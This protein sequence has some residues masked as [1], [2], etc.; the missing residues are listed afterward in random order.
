MR[1][2]TGG[3]EERGEGRRGGG[4]GGGGGEA[5]LLLTASSPFC[6]SR[7]TPRTTSRET[8]LA[9]RSTRTAHHRPVQDQPDHV[10][11]RQVTPAPGL[12][13]GLQLAPGAADHVLADRALE[14]RGQGS[15]HPPRVGTRQ[16][17]ARDQ[18]FD[19]ASSAA[20]SVARRRCATPGSSLPGPQPGARHADRHR[21]EG[22][23]QPPL[24]VAV[25]VPR[26]GAA[27]VPPLSQGRGQLLLEQLLDEAADPLPQARLDRVDQA[28]PA[29]RAA[30]AGRSVLSSSMAWSPPACHRRS[31][32]GERAGHDPAPRFRTTSAT[33]PIAF[34][35]G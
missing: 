32:L 21:P 10:L 1:R 20:R 13:V 7:R 34:E 4:E 9:L 27:P 12:P 18:G 28:S 16:V 29:N 31:W 26:R 22:A 17:G 19:L 35:V 8:L 30:S 24:P 2:H 11:A 15:L 3:R 23:G 25:P 14:Q 33:G 5:A 6:P